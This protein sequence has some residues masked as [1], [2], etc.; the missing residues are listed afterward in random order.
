MTLTF[1]EYELLKQVIFVSGA[2]AGFLVGLFVWLSVE[3]FKK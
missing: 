3:V 2:I 1:G